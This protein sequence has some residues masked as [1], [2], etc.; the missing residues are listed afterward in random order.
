MVFGHA[1]G[2]RDRLARRRD[3]VLGLCAQDAD[4]QDMPEVEISVCLL[5][6]LMRHGPFAAIFRTA[7]DL[8]RPVNW[9]GEDPGS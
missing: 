2:T 9:L 8:R 7:R 5:E 1:N 6:D 3:T 4:L